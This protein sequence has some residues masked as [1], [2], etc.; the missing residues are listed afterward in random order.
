MLERPFHVT[1]VVSVG[2][3]LH[4]FCLPSFINIWSFTM[5]LTNVYSCM[6]MINHNLSSTQLIFCTQSFIFIVLS[7]LL[8]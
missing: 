1:L 8:N 2:S 6:Y 5:V 4:S 3:E 7:F